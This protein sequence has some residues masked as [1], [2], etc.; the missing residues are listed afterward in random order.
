MPI[1][2]I[3]F[4]VLLGITFLFQMYYL[5][6]VFA[7]FAFHRKPRGISGYRPPVSVVISAHNEYQN[8]NKNLPQILK[9]DYADFEVVVVNDFSDDDTSELLEDLAREYK[10][11]KV[12]T[13]SQR[14]NFFRGKKFP[15]SIGIKATSY[16]H[17]L[18]TDADC[19]PASPYWINEMMKGFDEEAELVI[20]YGAYK[21][22][23]GLL[24]TIIRFETLKTALQYFS[25][26]IAGRPYMGVGRNIAYL[27]S[28]FYRSGGFVSHYQI[29][30]GDDDLFVNKIANQS[31]T[32][33]V[34]SPQSHTLS[35][36]ETSF[37]SWFRQ[38]KRHLSTGKYYK[39]KDK[40]MLG[41]YILT[42][43]LFYISLIVL[44][45]T[46]PLGIK[47]YITGGIGV[48]F[49]LSQILIF[50]RAAI[51]LGENRL[52]Y[53]AP[54]LELFFVI[55]EPVLSLANTVS[56]KNQWK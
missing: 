44:L 12:V 36:S 35:D 2:T 10:H 40:L 19:E 23:K 43:L 51:K 25:L 53:I 22:K 11:L 28:V 39:K 21:K 27:K 29:S 17:L 4:L 13:L 41:G 38:K 49:I 31:N 24:N 3:V 16:E 54:V 18:L 45:I 30:S 9:Q 20:G 6:G 26:A 32:R 33:V 8:L 50:Q 34:Y 56:S 7:K 37:G 42:R 15:L 47:L 14:L 48:F 46:L 55:W 1:L 5:W 52:G